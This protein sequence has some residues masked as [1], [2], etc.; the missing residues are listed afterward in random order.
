MRRKTRCAGIHAWLV[1][2]HLEGWLQPAGFYLR[3]RPVVCQP[4]AA[5]GGLP[6]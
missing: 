1:K 2:A 6:L 3:V 5:L 4:W